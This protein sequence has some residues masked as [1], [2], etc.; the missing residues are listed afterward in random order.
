MLV[1]VVEFSKKPEHILVRGIGKS[2]VRLFP[3]Y[4]RG[5]GRGYTFYHSRCM[6]SIPA[7]RVEDGKLELSLLLNIE[8]GV[9]QKHELVNEVVQAGTQVVQGFAGHQDDIGVKADP[10]VLNGGERSDNST[11]FIRFFRRYELCMVLFVQ[12][13]EDTYPCR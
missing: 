11:V 2:A 8:T 7:P 12:T 9:V 10:G 1:S 3:F 13:R 4:E 5:Y 6:G